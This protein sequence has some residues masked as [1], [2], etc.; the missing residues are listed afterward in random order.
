MVFVPPDGQTPR[1]V[2]ELAFAGLDLAFLVLDVEVEVQVDN[3][4]V[5][6]VEHRA[7]GVATARRTGDG[8]FSLR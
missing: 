8:G 2:L 1:H 5:V 4:G 7:A 3:R 6:C